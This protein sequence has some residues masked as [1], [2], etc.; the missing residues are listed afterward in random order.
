LEERFLLFGGNFDLLAISTD[1][2]GRLPLLHFNL[3]SL[4]VVAS[5]GELWKRAAIHSGEDGQAIVHREL[6]FL[7]QALLLWISLKRG[8]VFDIFVFNLHGYD[9]LSCHIDLER[10]SVVQADAARVVA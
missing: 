9:V 8:Q 3:I 4:R 10:N 1:L 7:H 2:A 6:P 5:L